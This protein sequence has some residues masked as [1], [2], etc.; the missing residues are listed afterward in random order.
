[1]IS[2]LTPEKDKKNKKKEKVKQRECHRYVALAGDTGT[3]FEDSTRGDV[4]AIAK[5]RKRKNED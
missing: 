1:M 2:W 5:R 3:G 4:F